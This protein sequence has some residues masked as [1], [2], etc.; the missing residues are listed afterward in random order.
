MNIG[1][2][3]PHGE[4]SSTFPES[5]TLTS[6]PVV[7]CKAR[8]PEAMVVSLAK[9]WNAADGRPE[10]PP[11]CVR[12]RTGRPKGGYAIDHPPIA[13]CWLKKYK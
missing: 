4:L 9:E 10:A 7:I 13:I 1:Y 5:D 3:P 2:I 12:T 8:A 6:H 11:V